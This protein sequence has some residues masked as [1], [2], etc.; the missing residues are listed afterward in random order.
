MKSLETDTYFY[1][2]SIEDMT[3][4]FKM[5]IMSIYKLNI[6]S[7]SLIIFNPF[8]MSVCSI[9]LNEISSSHDICPLLLQKQ[10]DSLLFAKQIDRISKWFLLIFI[11]RLRLL[12]SD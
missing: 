5:I 10:T 2:L 6:Q 9:I 1:Q 7:Y 8:R 3:L 4:K 12:G 11:M